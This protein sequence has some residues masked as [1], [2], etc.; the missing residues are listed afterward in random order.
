MVTA[1]HIAK[2]MRDSDDE[3]GKN[4]RV[5][6]IIDVPGV[7]GGVVGRLAKLDLPVVPYNGGEA[8]I[9]KERFVD[10][11]AEDCWTLRERF[12]QGEID[13]NRDDDKLAV[14]LSSIKGRIDSRGRIKIESKDDMR[15]RDCRHRIE[16]TPQRPHSPRG[17]TRPR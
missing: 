10:A 4:D 8:P 6:A 1:G 15:K 14:Q 9:D 13:I 2:A 5:R 17:G 7:G 12:E 3:A 11:R 16:P